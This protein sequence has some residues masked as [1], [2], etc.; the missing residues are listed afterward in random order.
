LFFLFL[1]L[2]IFVKDGL[3]YLFGLLLA[4]VEVVG[5]GTDDHDAEIDCVKPHVNMEEELFRDSRYANWC[6]SLT[7]LIL[8][9]GVGVNV[10][11]QYLDVVRTHLRHLFGVREDGDRVQGGDE[12]AARK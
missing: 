11:E 2:S 9:A 10:V 7:A 5:V 12:H 6:P 8:H 4:L 3:V 1:F